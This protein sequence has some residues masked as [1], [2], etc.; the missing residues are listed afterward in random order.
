MAKNNKKGRFASLFDTQRVGP[1]VKKEDMPKSLSFAF[2]FKLL[3]RNIN[4]LLRFNLLYVFGNFPFLFALYALTGNLN[5]N[6][7]GA[8]SPLFPQLHSAMLLSDGVASPAMM[9]LWGVHGVQATVSVMTPLTYTFFGL[10]A[11]I[12]L[13][14]GVVNVGVTY[15]IRSVLRGDPI[16]LFSDFFYA[17]KRN[18]KQALPV[19]I[20][21]CLVMALF[22]YNITLTYFNFGSAVFNFTFYGNILLAFTY[23]IMRYYIYLMMVTFDLKIWKL[24]KNAFIFS[25]LNFKRNILAFS[26]IAL[27]ILLNVYLFLILLPLGLMLPFFLTFS[28]C[29]FMGAYAAY[30]KIKEI[31]I[32]PYYKDEKPA[33][34]GDEPVFHDAG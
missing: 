23:S 21:D 20:L 7:F 18:W 11:L 16:F 22:T 13:T 2:F 31:M 3:G 34:E 27:V 32:D 17:I 8:A 1:G 30:P 5:T 26:G 10:S 14:F 12:L 25:I 24:F 9:A 33:A 28:L 29:A 19:G 15:L 6:S 4:N